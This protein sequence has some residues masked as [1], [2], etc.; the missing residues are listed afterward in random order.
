MK[1]LKIYDCSLNWFAPAHR[2]DNLVPKENDM[3]FDLKKYQK[4]LGIEYVDDYKLADRIITNTTYTPEILEWSD[5]HNI[6]LIK[7]MDGIFWRSDLVDRN[8]YLNNAAYQSDSVIFISKFSKDSFDKL[9]G[10]KLVNSYVVLNN[11]DDSIFY[12]KKEQNKKIKLWGASATNWE[13][14]EKRPDMLLKFADIIGDEQILLFGKSDDI[15]HKNIINAGYFDDYD[16]LSNSINMVDAWVNF[17]YRDAAPKTVLQAI[18]CNKPVLYADS[19]GLSEL[20]GNFG[21]SIEDNKD[22]TFDDENYEIDFELVKE[23]YLLFKQNYEI[24]FKP[25]E[26]KKYIE[27]LCEY[28]DIIKKSKRH[29]FSIFLKDIEI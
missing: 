9:Y 7:R 27:T 18:R 23:R 3:M 5:K 13:R 28:V 10:E 26:H 11:V 8:E 16:F 17:S 4:V 12:P 19:G 14:D 29:C 1:K 15:E 20:V 25:I 6:P 2:I 24:G 22:I 21:V